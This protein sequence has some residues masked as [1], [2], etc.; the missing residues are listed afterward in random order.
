[1][2]SSSAY[3]F[4]VECVVHV[5]LEGAEVVFTGRQ[6]LIFASVL[7]DD[8]AV[9]NGVDVVRESAHLTPP[10]HVPGV[11]AIR[12]SCER[13]PLELVHHVTWPLPV[14]Q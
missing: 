7:I 4:F 12:R 2:S 8:A 1:M 3:V 10:V 13:P 6:T 11:P 5:S 14:A 9:V